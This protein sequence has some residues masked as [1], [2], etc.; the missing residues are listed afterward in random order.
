MEQYPEQSSE[1]LKSKKSDKRSETS[2]KNI[3]KAQQVKSEK[4][5]LF[6]A[7]LDSFIQKTKPKYGK[8][9]PIEPLAKHTPVEEYDE[10]ESEYESSSN[11]DA[12]DI[13]EI[14][15]KPRNSKKASK[16]KKKAKKRSSSKNA[17]RSELEALKTM[18][19][20]LTKEQTKKPRKRREKKQPIVMNIN[21]PTYTQ[22][23][24]K[25]N[26]L[27]EDIKKKILINF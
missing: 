9:K 8:G 13:D 15:I 5:R 4:Q 18:L 17:M 10:S 14:V 26:P 6:R 20:N 19:T 21:P 1:Q 27:A 22:E 11:D 3:K 23:Q 16:K 24:P 2:R 12:S 25:A 7:E